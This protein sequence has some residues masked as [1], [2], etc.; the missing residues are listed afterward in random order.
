MAKV[1]YPHYAWAVGHALVLVGTVY[2]L[3]GLVTFSGRSKSYYLAYAGAIV[4]WGI[5]VVRCV[6]HSRLLLWEGRSRAHA[7][8]VDGFSGRQYKSLGS[9]TSQTLAR[10]PPEPPPNSLRV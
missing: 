8:V 7:D 1:S 3:L 10:T 2:T 6:L 9:L 5:V 4:S